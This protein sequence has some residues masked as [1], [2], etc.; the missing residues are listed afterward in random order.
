MNR[1]KTQ[2]VQPITGTITGRNGSSYRITT[3]AGRVLTAQ[4]AETYTIG[5][6]VVVI[7]GQII[8][9]AGRPQPSKI[10]EV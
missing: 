9:R 3:A 2:P 8:G 6:P 10:Y 4:S 5:D 7:A 1:L